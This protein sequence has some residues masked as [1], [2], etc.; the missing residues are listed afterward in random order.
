MSRYTGNVDTKEGLI[1][2]GFEDIVGQLKS[3]GETHNYFFVTPRKGAIDLVAF[4]TYLLMVYDYNL[5]K[6]IKD[7]NW[8]LFDEIEDKVIELSIDDAKKVTEEDKVIEEP[9]E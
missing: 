2:I 8:T 4:V 7:E 3:E 6:S 9:K 1:K 5:G